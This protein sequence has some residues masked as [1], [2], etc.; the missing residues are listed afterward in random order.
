MPLAPHVTGGLNTAAASQSGGS[1]LPNRA[2]GLTDAALL[3]MP[4]PADYINSYAL[5]GAHS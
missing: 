3:V 4:A 1:A 5:S 2:A